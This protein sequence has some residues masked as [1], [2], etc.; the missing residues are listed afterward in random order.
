M[1]LD[2][3]R[4]EGCSLPCDLAQEALNHIP[5]HDLPRVTSHPVQ[6]RAQ[7]LVCGSHDLVDQLCVNDGMDGRD[8]DQMS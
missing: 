8:R 4:H 1:A 5:A 7:R 6:G 2:T 3:E